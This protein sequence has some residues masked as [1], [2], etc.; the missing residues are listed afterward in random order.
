MCFT[1]NDVTLG[2]G[3]VGRATGYQNYHKTYLGVARNTHNDVWDTLEAFPR[4]SSVFLLI[5]P[6]WSSM[7]V[8][9]R[10]SSELTLSY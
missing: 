8:D 3:G 5:L 2:S 10:I 9:L 4:L 6:F 7:E 1:K